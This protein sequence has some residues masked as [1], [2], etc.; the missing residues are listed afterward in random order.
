MNN[1]K[2]F[3]YGTKNMRTVFKDGEPYFVSKDVCEILGINAT[4]TRRLDEDEKGMHL[5]QTPG[6]NQEM[7]II[8]ES[9]LYNLVLGSRNP[10]TKQF[11]R[12][13]THDVIPSI[14]KHGAY[15]TDDTLEKALTSPDFLIQLAT[16]LKEEQTQRKLLEDKIEIDKPKVVFAETCE[17]SKD[18]ILVRELAKLASKNG[19]KIGEKRLYDK[20][21]EWKMILKDR[22]EPMQTAMD[23]GYFQVKKRPMVLKSGGTIMTKTTMVTGKGQ[24]YIINKLRDELTSN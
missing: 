19:I 12:W 3:D 17:T 20:L 11:K 9:G 13:V 23:N 4:Q 2:V 6:G 1:L 24:V 21:R 14:R 16:K 8:N 5:I 10:E 15:M 22:T 18:C 7:Q